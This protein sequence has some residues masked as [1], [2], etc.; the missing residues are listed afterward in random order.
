MSRIPKFQTAHTPSTSIH[1]LPHTPSVSLSTCSWI[2]LWN[3]G[4]LDTLPRELL[5]CIYLSVKYQYLSVSLVYNSKIPDCSYT[6]YTHWF[7]NLGVSLC[8]SRSTVSR[9]CHRGCGNNCKDSVVIL[10]IFLLHS[11][12]TLLNSL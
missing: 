8:H 7:T 12:V 10:C 4:I 9:W 5:Y 3:S 2:L 11:T 6:L 1:K